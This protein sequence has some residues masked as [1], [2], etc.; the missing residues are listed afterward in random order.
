[1]RVVRVLLIAV[2]S[3]L[4]LAG[5][6]ETEGNPP[7][8][9]LG[10]P[11]PGAGSGAALGQ[12]GEAPVQQGGTGG[13]SGGT[14]GLGGNP[15]ASTP[16]PLEEC[17]QFCETLEYRLPRALCEDWNRPGWDPEF[18]H[19]G[20]TSDCSDYCAAVYGTVSPQCA[21]ML[22]AVIRCVAPTY[23]TITVPRLSE[24]WLEDCRDLLFTMTSA[25]YG[26]RQ[27]LEAARAAWSAN[28]ITDYELRYDSDGES[29][30]TVEVRAGAAPSVTPDGSTAWT[31]PE[32]FDEVERLL[33]TPS[34]A[35]GATYDAELGYVMS[36]I[37]EQDCDPAQVVSGVDVTPLP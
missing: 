32:L 28:G 6:G 35:P 14:G 26:L 2:V 5:C 30:A 15:G 10:D 1:M 37:R 9:A 16:G 24:C 34:V 20:N 29:Q 3:A 18:C 21:A 27:Q 33:G 11:A 8:A 12:A 4:G 17:E 13:R 36:L 19:V 7:A 22:P 23:A 31:V 25:C